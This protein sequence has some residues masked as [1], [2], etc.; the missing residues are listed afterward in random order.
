[1][2]SQSSLYH[3][4][5]AIILILLCSTNALVTGATKTKVV[6]FVSPGNPWAFT[7]YQRQLFLL[8]QQLANDTTSSWDLRW[9]SIYGQSSQ[10]GIYDSV[11]KY[12]SVIGKSIGG[13]RDDMSHLSFIGGGM[14]GATI[15]DGFKVITF[16]HLNKIAKKYD[17]D[18]FILL[19]DATKII[20]DVEFDVPAIFWLPQHFAKLHA[21]DIYLLC[22]FAAVVPLSPSVTETVKEDVESIMPLSAAPIIRH[23][24]HIIS[25]FDES[26]EPDSNI[27]ISTR[28]KLGI[29]ANTFVVLLQNGNY[30]KLDRKGFSEAIQAFGKMY[31]NVEQS[32]PNRPHLYIH[33]ITKSEVGLPLK[34]YLKSL[35]IPDEAWTL[36]ENVHTREMVQ[37]LKI[38]ADVCLHPSKTE[39]FGLNSLECQA[40]GTPS[41]T[42]EFSAMADF[43]F[44]GKAVP[45]RQLEWMHG[46]FCCNTR[47]S[48]NCCCFNGHL[49][50]N[51]ACG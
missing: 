40:L 13:T 51:Q 42:T 15:V 28:L 8:S 50:W 22:G 36:D 5:Q 49:P 25:V 41:V 23:I 20:R 18:A 10:E 39:G 33:A 31:R 12:A 3:A 47:R 9:F 21:N 11:E 1:M 45:P 6:C 26:N 34:R 48:G 38:M 2:S 29:D 32:Y 46:G 35:N 43:T 37:Y 4:V 44:L 7:P 14:G 19:M 24:P 30:D 27:R 17:I 16:S